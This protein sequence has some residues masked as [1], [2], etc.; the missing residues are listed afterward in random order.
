MGSV[1]DQGDPSRADRT[2]GSYVRPEIHKVEDT[3][4]TLHAYPAHM[5]HSQRRID[6]LEQRIFA[7][8]VASDIL[9]ELTQSILSEKIRE[10][11]NVISLVN[12]FT[13]FG[14]RT[15]ENAKLSKLLDRISAVEQ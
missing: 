5:Y 14:T 13:S 15:Y 10:Y 11:H 6:A 8:Q 7:L 1:I 2:P 9:G 3:G 12:T 4:P